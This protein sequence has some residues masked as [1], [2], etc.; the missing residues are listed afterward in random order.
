MN[1]NF[2]DCRAILISGIK[3]SQ[4]FAGSVRQGI[5]RQKT[6]YK[7]GNFR[8]NVHAG[9]LPQKHTVSYE[10]IF[11]EYSFQNETAERDILTKKIS[12][13]CNFAR[14]TSMSLLFP[15]P[16]FHLPL[17]FLLFFPLSFATSLLGDHEGICN[18]SS[19]QKKST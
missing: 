19:C 13:E 17:F 12:P 4:N 7:S 9:L 2:F 10:G 15:P 14:F 18:E 11:N 16:P 1:C 6:K 5:L 3:I 8:E